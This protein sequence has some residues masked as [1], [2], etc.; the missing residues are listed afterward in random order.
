MKRVRSVVIALVLISFL[1]GCAYKVIYSGEGMT[2]YLL[3]QDQGKEAYTEMSI[4]PIKMS[5]ELKESLTVNEPLKEYEVQLSNGEYFGFTGSESVDPHYYPLVYGSLNDIVD[6]LHLDL[7]V[8]DLAVYPKSDKNFLLLYDGDARERN[9]SILGVCPELE[10]NYQI[11]G[12]HIYL[13]FGSVTGHVRPT[14][15][16]IT[17]EIQYETYEVAGGEQAH[18]LYDLTVGKA[19]I[20]VRKEGAYYEWELEGITN[21][22]DLYEFADSIH[23]VKSSDC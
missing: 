11:S 7:L 2:V 5:E 9:I 6:S 15:R 18:F 16:E 17:E 1:S 3:D 4:S 12:V 14:L 21:L 23:W 10:K 20:F 13:Y 8:S 19:E 22:D